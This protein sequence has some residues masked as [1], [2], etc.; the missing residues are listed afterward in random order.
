MTQYERKNQPGCVIRTI[1]AVRAFP[2]Q[3]DEIVRAFNGAVTEVEVLNDGADMLVVDKW[4][5]RHFVVT[6]DYVFE[7]DL[8]TEAHIGVLS[9]ANFL[10]MYRPAREY[11]AVSA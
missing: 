9:P 6:G 4:G 8:V 11:R 10:D 5:D 2:S 1:T 7:N 3:A